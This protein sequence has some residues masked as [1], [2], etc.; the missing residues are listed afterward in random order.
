VSF[1]TDG[2]PVTITISSAGGPATGTG[3][4]ALSGGKR[5]N[6][7]AIAGAVI[8]VLL[9]LFILGLLLM[10]WAARRRRRRIAPS[11]AFMATYGNQPDASM[12]QLRFTSERSTTPAY[13]SSPSDS[14]HDAQLDRG[15]QDNSYTAHLQPTRQGI[16][17][18]QPSQFNE[19]AL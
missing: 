4:G 11:A 7:G 13:A 10:R 8:G 19:W 1:G 9:L 6:A 2:V 15:M 16:N 17:P 12:S 5:I 3:T 14:T 18:N